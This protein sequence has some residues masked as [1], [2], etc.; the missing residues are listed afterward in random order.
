MQ[1]AYKEQEFLVGINR[2]I[3]IKGQKVRTF[4]GREYREWNREKEN[5]MTERGKKRMGGQESRMKRRREGG[6]GKLFW[7]P[8]LNG[9]SLK[10][11]SI[12]VFSLVVENVLTQFQHL[13]WVDHWVMEIGYRVKGGKEITDHWRVL[14]PLDLWI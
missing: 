1:E 13:Q 10:K 6:T 3:R 14:L 4:Q 9:I 5:E 8:S 7:R 2:L 12:S 11:V